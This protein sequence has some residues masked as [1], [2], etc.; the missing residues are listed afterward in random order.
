MRHR[1]TQRDPQNRSYGW[2]YPY[3]V[4]VLRFAEA[5][6]YKRIAVARVARKFPAVLVALE[7]GD[8]HIT[9]A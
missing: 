7:N 6:A 5:V 9:G 4:N 1:R 3:C 2:I 8:L